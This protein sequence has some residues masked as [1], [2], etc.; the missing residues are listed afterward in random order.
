[1]GQGY[2]FKYLLGLSSSWP[3]FQLALISFCV[4]PSLPVTPLPSEKAR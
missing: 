3:S 2:L 4:P 1:M